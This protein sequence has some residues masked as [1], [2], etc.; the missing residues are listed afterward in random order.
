MEIERR[1][2]ESE[3]EQKT[4]PVTGGK[5]PVE[6]LRELQERFSGRGEAYEDAGEEVEAV[7]ARHS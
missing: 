1:E 5:V 3:Q 4:L 7:I 2:I 6:V